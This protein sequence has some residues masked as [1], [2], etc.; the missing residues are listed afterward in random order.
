MVTSLERTLKEGSIEAPEGGSDKNQLKRT[1]KEGSIATI[2][3][4]SCAEEEGS[5]TA[6][7]ITRRFL[8]RNMKRKKEV[9]M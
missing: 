9:R 4:N 3:A 7:I 6:A 5:E 1:L 8:Q 2:V